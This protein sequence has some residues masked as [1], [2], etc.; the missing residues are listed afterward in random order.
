M[1][2]RFLNAP[3]NRRTATQVI[4]VGGVLAPLLPQ[5]AEAK[6]SHATS[7]PHPGNYAPGQPG[8][9]YRPTEIPN[10][11][12]LPFIVRDGVKRVDMVIDEFDCTSSEHSRH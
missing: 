11:Y 7:V 5:L 8:V 6:G 12:K 4:A 9:D 3:L 2:A 10:G 1:Q